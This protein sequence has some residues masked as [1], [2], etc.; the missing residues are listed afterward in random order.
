LALSHPHA[1]AGVLKTLLLRK[2]KASP[3]AS[4]LLEESKA[5]GARQFNTAFDAQLDGI[6]AAGTEFVDNMNSSLPIVENL[7]LDQ[8]HFRVRAQTGQNLSPQELKQLVNRFQQ[9]GMFV[10]ESSRPVALRSISKELDEKVVSAM[11]QRLKTE[12]EPR[13]LV[14]VESDNKHVPMVLYKSSANGQCGYYGINMTRAEVVKQFLDNLDDPE[15]RVLL[16]K[17]AMRYL[18]DDTVRFPE[19]PTTKYIVREKYRDTLAAEDKQEFT[20]LY[21]AWE[22]IRVSIKHLSKQNQEETDALRQVRQSYDAELKAKPSTKA[23]QAKEQLVTSIET[24]DA[25][26]TAQ[27]TFLEEQAALAEKHLLEY[28]AQET[29]LRTVINKLFVRLNEWMA[30]AGDIDSPDYGDVIAYLNHITIQQ[31]SLLGT[32]AQ[33]TAYITFGPTAPT[34][35]LANSINVH[36]DRLVGLDDFRE[37]L[38]AEEHMRKFNLHFPHIA[39]FQ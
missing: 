33:T 19:S 18:K 3:F 30:V 15:V 22:S 5:D 4:I 1:D 2:A 25:G 17:V 29:V 21:E 27:K 13:P 26:F 10:D 11:F 32:F 39:A 37:Q 36:Y 28:L 12:I 8:Q 7:R 16:A 6:L 24:I 31:T 23:Q 20:S 34:K 38:M 9:T 35:C 14:Q